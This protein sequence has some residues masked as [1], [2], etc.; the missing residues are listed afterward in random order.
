MEAD[1][2]EGDE[3]E[4]GEGLRV[5]VGSGVTGEDGWT[6]EEKRGEVGVSTSWDFAA[7]I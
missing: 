7:F 4:D 5:K 3:G 2:D 1:E 6:R